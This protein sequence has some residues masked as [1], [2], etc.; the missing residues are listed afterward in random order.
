MPIR[1]NTSPSGNEKS[2]AAFSEENAAPTILCE[3]AFCRMLPDVVLYLRPISR[4]P[5]P[6]QRF[7]MSYRVI[8]NQ[9]KGFT[10]HP[11]AAHEPR[12]IS[13]FFTTHPLRG[14]SS[15]PLTSPRWGSC[16]ASSFLAPLATVPQKCCAFLWESYSG[17]C[18]AERAISILALP[19]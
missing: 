14:D 16:A 13:R 4:H 2:G 7:Y 17:G 15:A 19:V 8:Q 18:R 11:E 1:A 6:S 12:G 5:E 9:T 3:G 10:R